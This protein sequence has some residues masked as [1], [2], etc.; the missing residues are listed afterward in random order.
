MGRPTTTEAHVTTSA[1]ADPRQ[2]ASDANAT[3]TTPGPSNGRG[4]RSRPQT[5]TGRGVAS[6]ALAVLL[7]AIGLVL[8]PISIVTTYANYEVLNTE[9]FVATFAPLADNT[10]VRENLISTTTSTVVSALELDD[11]TARVDGG[12]SNLGL[13]E[14]ATTALSQLSGAA[15]QRVENLIQSAIRT[16]IESDQFATI[17][18]RTLRTTHTQLMATLKAD[19]NALITIAS[20]GAIELDLRPIIETVAQRLVDNGVIVEGAI[21]DIDRTVTLM[22]VDG[23]GRVPEITRAVRGCG[24][25]L[26]LVAFAFLA[27]GVLV[28]RRKRRAL[29][30]TA[31]AVSCVMGVLGVALL[32]GKPWAVSAASTGVLSAETAGEIYDTAVA[33]LALMV[34]LAGVLGLAIAAIAWVSRR[35]KFARRPPRDEQG[36]VQ[37]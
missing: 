22:R 11:L 7:V 2:P 36:V 31:L 21:P 14:R 19:R 25:W 4:H 15:A 8:T 16:T 5:G 18:Q 3:D 37:S 23:L 17:W 30:V 29:I 10:T 6:R 33:T 34:A 26:P 1:H 32:L 12:I 24:Y 9:R 13:P 35:V 28:A 20:T 27:A